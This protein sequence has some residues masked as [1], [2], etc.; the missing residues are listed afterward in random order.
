[1]NIV[2]IGYR[3]TGKTSVGC[4]LSRRLK[5]P[6]YDAD[7]VIEKDTAMSI[8]QMVSECGWDFFR[9][10]EKTAILKLANYQNSIIATGGGAVM[11]EENAIA[12]KKNGLFIWL[13]ADEQIVIKRMCSDPSSQQRRPALSNE[14]VVAET[15]R[16]LALRTPVYRRWADFSIDTS[17]LTIKEIVDD[18]C[19]FWENNAR[20]SAV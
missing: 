1:M 5:M 19:Q 11:D 10:K 14:D 9:Q 2:L 8:H 3:C 18:I 15:K 12:L 16:T 7:V 4:E 17:S 20:R 13:L 6:F